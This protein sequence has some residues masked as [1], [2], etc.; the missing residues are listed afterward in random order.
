MNHRNLFFAGTLLSESRSEESRL[1]G[2]K[3][4]GA[5]TTT[6]LP[7]SVFHF[8][9]LHYVNVDQNMVFGPEEPEEELKSGP[10]NDQRAI[11]WE[12]DRGRI[13]GT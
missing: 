6:R 1:L 5:T 4:E 12:E 9:R 8:K 2:P 11:N 3:T 7:N 13:M 10:V